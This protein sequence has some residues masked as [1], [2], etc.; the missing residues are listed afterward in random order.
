MLYYSKH[1]QY[2]WDKDWDKLNAEQINASRT[3]Q[4]MKLAIVGFSFIPHLTATKKS[5]E[6][7]G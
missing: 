6:N 5:H 4:V 3:V 2:Q 7:V 1:T